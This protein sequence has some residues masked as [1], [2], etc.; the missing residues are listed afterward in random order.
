LDTFFAGRA[1]ILQAS[2]FCSSV[3]GSHTGLNYKFDTGGFYEKE[4]ISSNVY[5]HIVSGVFACR[6]HISDNCGSGGGCKNLSP[7]N[8]RTARTAQ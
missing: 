7:T 6:G 4:I 3:Y 1:A 8:N 2:Q 5:G